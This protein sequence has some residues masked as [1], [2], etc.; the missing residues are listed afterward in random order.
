MNDLPTSVWDCA[1]G[2]RRPVG[3]SVTGED[4]SD[5]EVSAGGSGDLVVR[6][7]VSSRS[8]A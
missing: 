2:V 8:M 1:V 4:A 7:P 5:L 3:R 6:A